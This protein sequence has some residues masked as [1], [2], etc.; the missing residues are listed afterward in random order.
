MCFFC[1]QDDIWCENKV[2]EILSTINL[3][4]EKVIVHNAKVLLENADGTFSVIPE[5]LLD[6]YMFVLGQK[7]FSKNDIQF[8]LFCCVIQGMCMV[9]EREYLLSLLPFSRGYGHDHWIQF[10]STVDET[11]VAVDKVLSYYRIHQNNLC[12]IKKYNVNNTYHELSLF[13]RFRDIDNKT[14]GTIINQ[15]VYWIDCFEYA[16]I[17]KASKFFPATN[18]MG[19]V[20]QY[21]MNTRRSNLE[22][23]KI[24]AIIS[25]TKAIHYGVYQWDGITMYLHEVAFILWHSKDYRRK[26]LSDI[27]KRLRINTTSNRTNG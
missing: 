20:A 15:T 21:F 25:L 5:T 1:D 2:E 17:K 4:E 18:Q 6:N 16:S 12:G 22:K 10:C 24:P 27:D 14:V 19:E 7:K 11:I 3:P 26:K 23:S 13:K 8:R 9:A